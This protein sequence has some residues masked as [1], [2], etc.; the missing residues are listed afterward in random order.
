MDIYIHGLLR[1]L[2]VHGFPKLFCIW[3]FE[4]PGRRQFRSVKKAV[5][6]SEMQIISAIV[7]TP[8]FCFKKEGGVAGP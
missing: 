5:K 6:L 4:L 7:C 2:K 1:I 3:L 8:P